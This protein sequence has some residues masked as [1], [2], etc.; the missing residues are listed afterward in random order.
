MIDNVSAIAWCY[1]VSLTSDVNLERTSATIQIKGS[2]EQHAFA[3]ID[4]GASGTL[5]KRRFSAQV[6][7]DLQSPYLRSKNLWHRTLC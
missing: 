3:M 5:Q 7:S 4:W 2:S 6:Y 1:V